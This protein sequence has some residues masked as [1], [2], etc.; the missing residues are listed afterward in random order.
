MS[1][2]ELPP[3]SSVYSPSLPAFLWEN[4]L[5][6]MLS[7]YQAGKLLILSASAPDKISMLPRHFAKPM[8][9]AIDGDRMAIATKGEV[10]LLQQNAALARTYLAKPNTYD[11]L[12]VPRC[13]YHTGDLDIHDVHFGKDGEIWAVNTLFSSLVQINDQFSF[14]EKWRPFF[15]EESRPEDQCHLNGLAMEEGIP[16]YIS[17][18]GKTTKGWAWKEDI[19]SGGIVMDIPSNEIVATGLAMPHSP[20][21]YNGKILVLESA[22]QRL[23]QIEPSSGKKEVIC[24]VAGFNRGMKRFGDFLFI[25]RSKLRKESTTFSKLDF[26]SES[27]GFVVVDLKRGNVVAELKFLSSVDEI[28]DLSLLKETKRPNVINTMTDLHRQCVITEDATYWSQ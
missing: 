17:A 16:K 10:T 3:F 25:G 7:T 5:S 2:N 8:G 28:Y 26:K 23:T 9:I 27:A 24:E 19:I 20:I 14:T 12:F 13:T 11:K 21:I 15:I 18:L 22:G 4:N 1:N 6:I